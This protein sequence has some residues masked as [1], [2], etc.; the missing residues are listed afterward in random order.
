MASTIS[1]ARAALHA[2]LAA[3]T[4]PGAVPQVTFGR[5]DVYEEPEVIA[6]LGVEAPDEEPA[7]IGGPKPREERFTIVVAVKAHDPAGTAATVDARGWALMDEV[8][9]VVYANQTLSGALSAPGWARIGSQTSEEG[10]QPAEG[11]GWVLFGKV[12][13]ACRARLT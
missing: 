6:L 2:L 7:V 9:E 1:A 10:A 4:Y 3:N 5:P 13:V 8:R 12:R 11:G